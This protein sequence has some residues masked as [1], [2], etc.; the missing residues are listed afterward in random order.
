MAQEWYKISYIARD[1]RT[2]T[3]IN[4][5]KM[6]H[7][8]R[9]GAAW[10]LLIALVKHRKS[11][12]RLIGVEKEYHTCIEHKPNWNQQPGRPKKVSDAGN[13]ESIW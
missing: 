12:D 4:E 5:S 1:I 7:V 2:G 6:V 3:T 13:C 9:N 10:D 8:T 11:N